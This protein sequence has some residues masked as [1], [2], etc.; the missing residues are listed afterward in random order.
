MLP[1]RTQ[2]AIEAAFAGVVAT[3]GSASAIVALLG[4]EGGVLSTIAGMVTKAASSTAVTGI[5]AIIGALAAATATV[6][7]AFIQ[8]AGARRGKALASIE[9]KVDR[10]ATKLDDQAETLGTH[11]TQM[12]VLNNEFA[13]A[14]ESLAH[15]WAR[16]G[17]S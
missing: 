9:A 17:G 10:L 7:A 13:H 5:A 2:H 16:I 4:G 3:V 11:T 12:A 14:K 8:S 15:V 1:P 6:I